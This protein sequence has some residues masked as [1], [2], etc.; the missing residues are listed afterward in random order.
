MSQFL[1]YYQRPNPATWV[2]LSSFLTIGLYFVFH[3]FWSIRNV[4]ILL[5]ILLGPGVLLVHEGRRQQLAQEV[6]GNTIPVLAQQRAE[7]IPGENRK[8]PARFANNNDR[9]SDHS[10]TTLI[11]TLGAPGPIVALEPRLTPLQTA[12]PAP[13]SETALP[14]AENLD[15]NTR[16][17]DMQNEASSDAIENGNMNENA[18]GE[19]DRELSSAQ[20]LELRGFLWLL[21]VEL[22]ILIRLFFDPMMVRRPLLDPN[23]TTG[24]L[25]FIGVSLLIFLL[26]NV[27]TST[28][29]TQREQGPELG[30]GYPVLSMLPAIPTTPDAA[31]ANRTADDGLR[32]AETPEQPVAYA[33]IARTIA[34]LAHLAVIFG[35]A[36]VGHWHF[37]NFKAGVG[38]ATLYLLL[39]YTAQMT[40]RV[41]HVLPAALLVWA[42]LMYRRPLVAGICLGLAAG[43]VYYPAFLIPL[44]LGFYRQRGLARFASGVGVTVALLTLLLSIGGSEQFSERLVQMYGL[45]LPLR[46]NLDGVWGLSWQPIWRFPIL[47]AYVLLAGFFAI[48][49]RHKNLGT[50]M[51]CSA[52]L[53]VAAQFWHGFGG[54]LFVAWFLP[55]LLLTIFRP[56]LEDRV[57][58]KVIGNSSGRRFQGS[59]VGIE[60]AVILI[61][62]SLSVLAILSAD[63]LA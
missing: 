51:S 14:T 16:I 13:T 52:A 18:S 59:A 10:Q 55:L 40:G 25:V 58:L 26:A 12:T 27:I 17:P 28:P 57:A 32:S 42:I 37:S 35:I 30:P 47:V 60:A 4:D 6:A 63:R 33:A 61:A 38:C 45:W 23:L 48:W 21:A 34:I 8:L 9:D 11:R 50:L 3:R 39:P 19:R 54:G 56:N 7:M 22:V 29:R 49:P 5:L 36:L 53:M 20:R 41:D 15:A 62:C 44:W 46:E 24:G 2:Y 31:T 43:L 1:L